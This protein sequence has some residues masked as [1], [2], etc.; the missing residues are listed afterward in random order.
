[1]AFQDLTK[2]LKEHQEKYTV[3]QPFNV[4]N[5]VKSVTSRSTIPLYE[6]LDVLVGATDSSR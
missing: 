5:P 2:F 4:V 1:M 3:Y 6:K